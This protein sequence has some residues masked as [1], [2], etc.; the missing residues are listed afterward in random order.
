METSYEIPFEDLGY[1][2]ELS[3]ILARQLFSTEQN[4]SASN[5]TSEQI[6]DSQEML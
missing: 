6:P 4:R 3:F 1:L 2:K 5:A